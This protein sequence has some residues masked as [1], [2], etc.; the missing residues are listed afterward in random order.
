[1][2]DKISKQDADYSPGMESKHC[3]LCEHYL[4]DN[5]CEIVA[6]FIREDYWCRFFEKASNKASSPASESK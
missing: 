5:R 6:G 2:S 3:A 1:M 4:G